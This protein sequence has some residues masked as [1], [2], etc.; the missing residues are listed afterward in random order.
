MDIRGSVS[1]DHRSLLPRIAVAVQAVWDGFDFPAQAGTRAIHL[2][3]IHRRL[4]YYYY[5]LIINALFYYKIYV[6]EVKDNGRYSHINYLIGYGRFGVLLV[7]SLSTT[8][9]RD[10]RTLVPF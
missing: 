7:L 6:G 4:I 8:V 10:K 3:F 5:I 1:T 2:K 9:D